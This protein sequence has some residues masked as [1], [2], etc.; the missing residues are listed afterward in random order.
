MDAWVDISE[1]VVTHLKGSISLCCLKER[2]PLMITCLMCMIAS[3]RGRPLTPHSP[4]RCGWLDGWLADRQ[5]SS[6]G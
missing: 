6:R 5:A 4:R 3:C 1:D 2:K